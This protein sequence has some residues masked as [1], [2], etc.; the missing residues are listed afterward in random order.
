MPIN[1]LNLYEEVIE[2]LPIDPDYA[3]RVVKRFV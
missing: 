1:E 2:A 3:K